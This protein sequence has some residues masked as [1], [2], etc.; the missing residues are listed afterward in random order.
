MHITGAGMAMSF[1]GRAR[2]LLGILSVSLLMWPIGLIASGVEI[3]PFECQGKTSKTNAHHIFGHISI[4]SNSWNFKGWINFD[5]HSVPVELN[6]KPRFILRV[7]A[8]TILICDDAHFP[9][10]GFQLYWY[11]EG[12]NRFTII[13]SAATD[14]ITFADLSNEFYGVV[15]SMLPS[16][17]TEMFAAWLWRQLFSADPE[18]ALE[19]LAGYEQEFETNGRGGEFFYQLWWEWNKLI[20]SDVSQKAEVSD[21]VRKKTFTAV[22]RAVRAVLRYPEVDG[23]SSLRA[24]FLFLVRLDPDRAGEFLTQLLREYRGLPLPSGGREDK[25]LK[26]KISVLTDILIALGD[27]PK[28]LSFSEKERVLFFT[29]P[30]SVYGNQK[31]FLPLLLFPYPGYSVRRA[32]LL[33]AFDPSLPGNIRIGSYTFRGEDDSYCYY[34]DLNAIPESPE[35]AAEQIKLLNEEIAAAGDKTDIRSVSWQDRKWLGRTY[36]LT[37]LKKDG[38]RIIFRYQVRDLYDEPRDP[39]RQRKVIKFPVQ[40]ITDWK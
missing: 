22:A 24:L 8:G 9:N 31:E 37:V 20:R 28:A 4:G 38:S 26:M 27:T 6:K 39:K 30:M 12:E 11:D 34:R 18:R 13:G 16:P 19:I 32:I 25:L 36:Q 5:G 17:F 2:R 7:N 10:D 3:L 23:S 15:A 14:S 29:S 21:C 33:N 1:T 40:I 35:L